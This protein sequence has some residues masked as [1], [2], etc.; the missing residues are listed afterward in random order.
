MR[1]D[2]NYTSQC[3]GRMVSVTF[4]I[5]SPTFP[6]AIGVTNEKYS[7]TPRAKYPVLYLLHGVGNNK[8]NWLL[9]TRAELYAEENNIA[10][11]CVSAENKFYTDRQGEKWEEFLLNEL[12]ELACGYFPIS[13]RREDTYVAGLSMGGYGAALLALTAPQKYAACGCFSGAIEKV[14]LAQCIRPA[15]NYE[16]YTLLDRRLSEGSTLPAL[17]VACGEDDMIYDNSLRLHE[18]LE[19]KGVK[20]YWESVKG[21]RHEWR[22]W[23]MQLEKFIKWLPRTDEYKGKTRNV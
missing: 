16:I 14:D 22:F 6:D 15:E 12:P 3:L 18:T 2:C 1:I 19:A 5:P 11:C 20:H 23:D 9:Y 21:Y 17:Y 4:I 10:V 13:P 8:D 7:L